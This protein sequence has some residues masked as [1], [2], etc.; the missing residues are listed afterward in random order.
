MDFHSLLANSVLRTS[1]LFFVLLENA[2]YHDFSFLSQCEAQRAEATLLPGMRA[3]LESL[4]RRHTSALELMGER[5]EEVRVQMFS[6]ISLNIT[7]NKHRIGITIFLAVCKSPKS[8]TCH[9]WGSSNKVM[10]ARNVYMNFSVPVKVF[11]L[12]GFQLWSLWISV[13]YIIYFT[14]LYTFL[15]S[16]LWDCA[17][18]PVQCHWMLFDHVQRGYKLGCGLGTGGG[19]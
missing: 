4:R 10:Y 11:L 16:S 14:S 12:H 19:A 13:L 2:W 9:S 6:S 1:D 3:E 8:G 7:L 18:H 15:S 5:D 17:F